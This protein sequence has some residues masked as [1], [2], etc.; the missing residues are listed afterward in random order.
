MWHLLTHTAGLTYGFHHAHPVDAHVP[1]R[2]LRVGRAAGR[3]PR[4]RAATRGRRCRWCSSP[5]R[6]GTTGV[7][8]DVLGRRGRGRRRAS[9]STRSSR[10]R[11]FGPLGMTDTA[12]CVGRGP[13]T[14]LAALYVAD[15]GD[16]PRDRSRD[17]AHGRRRREA[18]GVPVRRRRAGV[19]GR[20]TTTASPGCCWRGGELDGVRLLGTRTVDY[21][22]R[23]H[24]PGGVD[25]EAFGR[26]LFAE[27]TVR[28][29]RASAS[30][31]RWC[32][33]PS[34]NTV[35]VVSPGEYR[36]GRRGEHR[37]LGRPGRGHHRRVLHPAAA[38][39]ART[40]SARSCSSSCTRRWS[41]ESVRP[42]RTAGCA[43]TVPAPIV[44][45][46]DRIGTKRV[47]GN[48]SDRHSGR[49]LRPCGR[50]GSVVATR[51]RDEHRAQPVTDAVAVTGDPAA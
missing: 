12:F 3:R 5:A 38:R 7:S 16:G 4:R 50:L 37:V 27:T 29:R 42:R 23:N 10:E 26:P 46:R 9:R 11:I 35:L 17:D 51:T 33:T 40:R 18:A 32:T 36:L 6:S 47:H 31:S 48:L 41:T 1:R 43:A 24:L 2:R 22:A 28:R 13:P 19:D 8:T 25:L 15:P 21:M 34:A 44:A 39:R 45:L 14:A 30:G 49:G 20:A